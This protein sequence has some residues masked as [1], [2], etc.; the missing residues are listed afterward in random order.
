MSKEVFNANGGW[1][2]GG[3]WLVD[4]AA[5]PI[6][7]NEK[8]YLQL[9]I[10]NSTN[11]AANGFVELCNNGELVFEH[12]NVVLRDNPGHPP[13]HLELTPADLSHAS[14]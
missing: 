9:H 7:V 5:D 1:A 3:E 12:R 14:R 2:P 13:N 6:P 8:P 11:G 4:Y 10:R